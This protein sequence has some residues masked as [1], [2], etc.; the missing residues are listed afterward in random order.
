MDINI[1]KYLL[2]DFIS[3]YLEM[4]NIVCDYD[5][6]NYRNR[7]KDEGKLLKYVMYLIRFLIMGIEILKIY[8]IN[9]YWEKEYVLLM[10]IRKGKYSYDELFKLVEL[11]DFNFKEVLV[12][13]ILFKEFDEV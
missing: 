3:I 8:E 9:I 10:D 11:Y 4:S 12:K 1:D 5:K 7:K 2:R 6:F 13:I